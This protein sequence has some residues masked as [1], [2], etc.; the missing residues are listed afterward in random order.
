MEPVD[1]GA[2]G[3]GR[4]LP[5]PDPKRAADRGEAED[6]LQLLPDSVDEELPAVFF[7]VLESGALHLV[8]HHRHDV[9]HL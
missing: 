3:D 1:A 6:D 8:P 2:V 9:L 7:R 4:E 5:P